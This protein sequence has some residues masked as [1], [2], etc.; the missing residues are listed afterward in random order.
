MPD[1]DG[2]AS[3]VPE[4]DDEV[5]VCLA[6]AAAARDRLLRLREEQDALANERDEAILRLVELGLSYDA[7][8]RHAGVSRARVGQI[9]VAARAGRAG[10]QRR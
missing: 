7:V 3:R 8:S 10:G 6:R 1:R 4:Q 2:M 5:S 9:V